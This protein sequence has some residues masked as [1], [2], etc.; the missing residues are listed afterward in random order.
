MKKTTFA[1]LFCLAAMFGFMSICTPAARADD[2]QQEQ[3]AAQQAQEE[4]ARQAAESARQAEELNRQLQ[5]SQ[6]ERQ[7]QLQQQEEQNQQ[8]LQ[9]QQ[10]QQA[11]YQQREQEYEAQQAAAV[12]QQNEQLEQQNALLNQPTAPTQVENAGAVAVAPQ[13]MAAP[14]FGPAQMRAAMQMRQWQINHWQMMQGI[15]TLQMQQQLR[16][17]AARRW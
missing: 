11:D 13:A 10:Q 1:F 6:E 2:A 17:A 15:R 5:Q 16:I 7:E 12:Q 3:L 8:M 4:N 14:M 9:E